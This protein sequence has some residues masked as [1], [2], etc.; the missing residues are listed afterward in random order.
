MELYQKELTDARGRITHA[1]RK[2]EDFVFEMEYLPPESEG[3]GMFTVRYEVRATY[4]PTGK[5]LE[6]IGGIGMR[7]VDHFEDALKDGLFD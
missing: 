5:R 2:P 4:E 1:G 6:T 3:D 7:W